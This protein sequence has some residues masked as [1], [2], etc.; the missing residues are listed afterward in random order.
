M[1]WYVSA[2]NPE[3]KDGKF[4]SAFDGPYDTERKAHEMG[5]KIYPG[6]MFKKWKYPTRNKQVATGMWKHDLAGQVGA[7]KA[8]K[9]VRHLDKS[10]VATTATQDRLSE[11]RSKIKHVSQ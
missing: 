3:P 6:L 1:Y 11:M 10:K 9:P 4:D 8:L 7:F 5:Q 2:E